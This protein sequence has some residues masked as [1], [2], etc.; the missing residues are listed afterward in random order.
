MTK[1][2]TQDQL[3]ALSII[4]SAKRILNNDSNH[5]LRIAAKIDEIQRRY[6]KA[7][8]VHATIKNGIPHI[9]KADSKIFDIVGYTPS[10]LEGQPLT[11]IMFDEMEGTL[12]RQMVAELAENGMCVKINHNRHKNGSTVKTF[13]WIFKVG[14]NS[15]REFVMKASHVLGYG[16]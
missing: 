15:Y 9:T 16:I 6:P 13:G 12:I 4:K 14:E 11:K 7:S 8:E 2:Y 5:D 1:D 10:E 3:E